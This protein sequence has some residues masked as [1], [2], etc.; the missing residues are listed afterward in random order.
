MILIVDDDEIVT[1]LLNMV[2]Q[3]DGY[4]TLTAHSGIQ[5][6]GMLENQP[7]VD[8]IISDIMMKNMDGLELL[9]RLQGSAKWGDIPVILCTAAGNVENVR[10][11][12]RLGCRY[13]LLKPVDRTLLLKR[14]SEALA[15]RKVEF[16]GR[17][18]I[19][20]TQG[21][22]AATYDDI[23][24]EFDQNLSEKIELFEQTLNSQT[25]PSVAVGI[26]NLYESAVILGA[27]RLAGVLKKMQ[28]KAM[29]SPLDID[30]Y[31]TLLAE[32]KRLLGKINR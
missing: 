20:K 27:E 32:I 14:V 2:L 13:F 10:K 15:G 12:G 18:E 8:L 6:V 22:D 1:R 31:R 21:L 24:K 9:A 11:A 25:S 3:Q 28:D 5:A 7:D 30:D 26:G 17:E 23:L 16:R 4:S 29:R 19:M